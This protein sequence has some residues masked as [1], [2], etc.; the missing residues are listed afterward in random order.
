LRTHEDPPQAEL[1]NRSFLCSTC[2]A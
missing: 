1:R 2:R